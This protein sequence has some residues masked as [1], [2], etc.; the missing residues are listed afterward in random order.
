MK[1]DV[2]DEESPLVQGSPPSSDVNGDVEGEGKD[3]HAPPH[4]MLLPHGGGGG[5]SQGGRQG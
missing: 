3:D 1:E 5:V 2:F 4:P